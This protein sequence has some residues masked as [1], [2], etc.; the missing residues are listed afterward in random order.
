MVIEF[1]TLGKSFE[2]A[3]TV[4]VSLLVLLDDG[5]KVAVVAVVDEDDSGLLE[6]VQ[7]TPPLLGSLLTV[8]LRVTESP[9][10]TIEGPADVTLTSGCGFE[11]PPLDPPPPQPAREAAVRMSRIDEARWL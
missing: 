1:E 9:A 8:A 10:S 7:V 6:S 2:V 3:V 5:T 4:Y 11:P